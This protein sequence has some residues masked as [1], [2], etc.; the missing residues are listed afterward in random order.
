MQGLAAGLFP[1]NAQP[2]FVIPISMN[3]G[4]YCTE[5]GY[6]SVVPE[7]VDEG[8]LELRRRIE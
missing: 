6:S 3:T 2:V 8:G 1:C 4:L 5:E 7:N